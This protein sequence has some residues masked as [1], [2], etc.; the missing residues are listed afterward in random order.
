VAEEAGL[1]GMENR[2]YKER[3]SLFFLEKR[4]QKCYSMTFFT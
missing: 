2:L 4:E 1:S 3:Q